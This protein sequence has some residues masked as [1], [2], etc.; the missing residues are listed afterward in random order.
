MTESLKIKS[1]DSKG[2]DRAKALEEILRLQK[3]PI[4]LGA[5]FDTFTNSDIQKY[6]TEIREIQ[7]KEQEIDQ[8]HA[9]FLNEHKK[10]FRQNGERHPNII[11]VEVETYTYPSQELPELQPVLFENN[12]KTALL[13]PTRKIR[14]GQET[15]NYQ[16]GD[17][18]ST[19]TNDVLVIIKIEVCEDGTKTYFVGDLDGQKPPAYHKG[20][21]IDMIISKTEFPYGPRI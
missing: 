3:P 12:H 15:K 10:Y 11:A 14:S 21:K 20:I 2:F 4:S 18:I 19:F 7:K 9:G 16:V 8:L 5:K 1:P 13:Y 6:L 17:A